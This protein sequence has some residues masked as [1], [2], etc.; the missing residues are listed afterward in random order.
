MQDRLS[1]L[2]KTKA[3]SATTGPR[4][5]FSFLSDYPDFP[6]V[7]SPKTAG[8]IAGEWVKENEELVNQKL[9]E[10]GALLLRGFHVDTVEK[11][12]QFIG[13]FKATPLQYRQRSSPRFEVAENVYHSTTYPADQ[14]INMH[15]ENSY[16]PQWAMRITFCC[17]QPAEQQGE[18]PIADNRKVLRLIDPIIREKFQTKGVQYVRNMSAGIGL[19]WQEVFQT[20][21]RQ[22]VEEECHNGGM[23][24]R[25]AGADS[26]SLSW[27]HQAIYDHPYTQEPVWF[28]HAFFFNKYALPAEVQASFAADGELPFHTRYGD[29]SEISAAEI[30]NIRQAYEQATV[31]FPWQ[32]GDVLLLD[33]MLMS[34]GRSPYKGSRQIIV[35]MF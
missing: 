35:S 15:S 23:A 10:H 14:H 1:K 3:E 24:F 26:L 33:N 29:G 6:L 31:R 17:I 18:T 7:V 28:N 5:T 27:E 8:L 34:H 32:K 30:D 12:Q 21:D 20:T 13:A 16:A 4:A 25:W 11:F 19:P 9:N 22:V 2:L